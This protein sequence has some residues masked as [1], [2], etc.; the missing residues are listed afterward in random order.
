V[1]ATTLGT[2][3]RGEIALFISCPEI[4]PGLMML[5]GFAT[6]VTAARIGED[7]QIGQQVTIGW[8]DRGGCPTIGDRVRVGANSVVIGPIHIDDDAVIGAGAVVIRDVAA[9][10]VVGGVPAKPLRAEDRFRSPLAR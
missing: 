1:I 10:T 2:L 4:G 6:I 7:C 9:G 8:D 5:H 3:Y